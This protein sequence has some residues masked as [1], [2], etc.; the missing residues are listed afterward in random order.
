LHGK[1]TFGIK[2]PVTQQI[3]RALVENLEGFPPAARFRA[4]PRAHPA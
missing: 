4:A 3:K 2:T 1:V